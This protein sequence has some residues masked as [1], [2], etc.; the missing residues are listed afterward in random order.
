MKICIFSV[1]YLHEF[2]NIHFQP[3]FS[4]TL[5]YL[6]NKPADLMN[7]QA[8]NNKKYLSTAYVLLKNKQAEENLNR[9]VK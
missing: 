5:K 8:L 7:L 3:L 4:N 2:G 6:S 9:I 1:E